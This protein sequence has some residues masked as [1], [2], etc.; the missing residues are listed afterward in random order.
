MIAM[1]RQLPWRSTQF[2]L[3]KSEPGE[4]SIDD[5]AASPGQTASWTGVRNYQARNL[6]RDSIKLGDRVF[7][8]HSSIKLT[9]IAG[10]CQ[11][12]REAY[13]DPTAL[14]PSS[15][16][17]DPKATAANPIWCAVDIR[18]EKKFGEL[19]PLSTLKVTP[20]LENMMVC[21]R[22][23]RLSIQ[24]VTKSE[25]EVIHRLVEKGNRR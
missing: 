22:G 14:D 13:L 3:F 7:F 23:A 20:G 8:Y 18:L 11:V 25:W 21:R 16:Y 1:A 2:W 15:D 4:F 12:V 5:L 19:I 6:L 10:T 9:G 24:P 17:F